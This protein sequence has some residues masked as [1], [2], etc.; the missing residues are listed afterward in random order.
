MDLEVTKE[1]NFAV[2]VPDALNSRNREVRALRYKLHLYEIYSTYYGLTVL[3][4]G[5]ITFKQ[6][7]VPDYISENLSSILGDMGGV[8]ELKSWS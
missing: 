5:G 8:S 1:N 3:I 2:I 4:T 6:A 7:G